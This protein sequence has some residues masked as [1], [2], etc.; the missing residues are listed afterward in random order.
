MTR[1][2][3]DGGSSS[4]RGAIRG[5]RGGTWAFALIAVLAIM[6]SATVRAAD[7]DASA[8]A[9]VKL[10]D[11]WSKAAAAKDT[12]RVVSFYADDA[13]V[14]PPDEP[15]AAGR[16]AAAKVWGAYFA[17]PEFAISW[18][19][20]HAQVSGDLGFTTGTYEDSYKGPDGKTVNE[21]GKYVCLWKKQHDGTWKSIHDMWNSDAK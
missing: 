21:K 14:Y 3:F 11:D 9:L 19:T 1:Y 20:T 18:K 6:P 4:V 16:A 2:S 13:L 10:D 17:I 15:L 12:D 5:R 8:R 7:M